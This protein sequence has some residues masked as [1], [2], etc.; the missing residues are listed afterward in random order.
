MDTL[1]WLPHDRYSIALKQDGVLLTLNAEGRYELNAR[2]HL[3]LPVGVR[4]I[5]SLESGSLAVLVARPKSN[6][7]LVHSASMVA[8]IMFQHYAKQGLF[9]D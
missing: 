7:L 1:G 2:K 9:H 6:S 5:L 3:F 8:A 4:R